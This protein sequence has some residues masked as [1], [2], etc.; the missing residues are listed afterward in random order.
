MTEEEELDTPPILDVSAPP[1]LVLPPELLAPATLDAPPVALLA[2]V[3]DPPRSEDPS[4]PDAPAL[5]LVEAEEPPP[6]ELLPSPEFDSLQAAR[7]K[8]IN[9]I[10]R[11]RVIFIAC[12]SLPRSMR[13]LI[14][15]HQRAQTWAITDARRAHVTVSCL[16]A[17]GTFPG[18]VSLR[19]MQIREPAVA[20]MFYPGEAK[21]LVAAVDGFLAQ[22]RGSHAEPVK[23]V[24]APHAGY[25][26]SGPIA[27]SAY[28]A[29]AP[30]GDS[31]TRVV[32]VGPSHRV[33]FSGLATS[34]AA[35]FATPLGV[36]PVDRDAVRDL[37]KDAL[38]HENDRAHAQEHSLEVHLPFVQR[39]FPRA[40]VIPLLAGDDDYRRV[41]EM[42]ER[43]WGGDETAI[44][45][46]SD[47]SHYL[48]YASA[49]R[50]DRET[51]ETIESRKAGEVNFDQA[52]GATPI[53]G[54]LQVATSHGLALHTLDL[55]NSGDTAGPR[56][57][58]VGYGAF[59]CG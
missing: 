19:T 27:G 8:P 5:A 47:L 37:L 55:R 41:A 51:A 43:L 48:D 12:I 14:I 31:V 35:G 23:A 32:V 25:V 50:V 30:R 49:C 59:A 54:L 40:S 10:D 9:R 45:V 6:T 24:I 29:L 39:I 38:V 13:S 34:S 3:L 20:G 44:V 26:Y 17:L 46:S 16:S 57:E 18:Q 42:L 7:R 28:H 33:P 53:N 56:A 11:G 36:L 1:E 58:V 4:V 15:E 2:T 52:C 21:D 22:A